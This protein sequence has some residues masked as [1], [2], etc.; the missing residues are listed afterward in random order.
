MSVDNFPKILDLDGS[1]TEPA[2][3]SGNTGQRIPCFDSC[4]LITKCE[5]KHWL[6]SV[7]DGR[8][9]GRSFNV[10]S[11]DYQIFWGWVDLLSYGA[12]PVHE[13][14]RVELRYKPDRL[15]VFLKTVCSFDVKN[16]ISRKRSRN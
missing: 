2:I 1:T 16:Y 5:S 13:R 8:S 7:A 15:L 11:R 4:Q 3:P 9:L 14:E 6:P 10:R 12:P